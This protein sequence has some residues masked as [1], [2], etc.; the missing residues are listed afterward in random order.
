MHDSIG[1]CCLANGTA[2]ASE[3][4]EGEVKMSEKDD[5]RDLQ[6]R[7]HELN[8]REQ[9]RE[10]ELTKHEQDREHELSKHEH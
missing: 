5:A 10:H 1:D 4:R 3:N 7:E 8:K 2:R 6:D 9:D